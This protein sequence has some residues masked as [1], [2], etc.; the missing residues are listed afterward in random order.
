MSSG[1][2][3]PVALSWRKDSRIHYT[4]LGSN[5][6]LCGRDASKGWIVEQKEGTCRA[7]SRAFARFKHPHPSLAE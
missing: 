3:M 1:I 6:T 4:E 7:C 2:I 5:L